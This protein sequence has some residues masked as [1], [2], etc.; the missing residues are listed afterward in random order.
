M[1]KTCNFCS[2]KNFTEKR[3]NY[4]YK[5]DDKYLMVNDV[6]CEV[7]DFCGEQYFKADVLKKI[8]RDYN[9]I[10]IAGKKTMKEIRI[11]VE[12]FVNL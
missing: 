10:Y 8:E 12:E 3:I 1:T 9:D 4:I 7:C 11:P 6:P 2:N 5:R